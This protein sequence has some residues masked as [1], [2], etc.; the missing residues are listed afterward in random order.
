M[1]YTLRHIR[2]NLDPAPRVTLQPADWLA[3]GSSRSQLFLWEAFVSGAAHAREANAA[4]LQDHLVDAATA[5]LA[6]AQWE[7][8]IPRGPSDVT[9]QN[10]ISTVGAAVLWSGLASDPDLLHQQTLVLRPT[11]LLGAGIVAYEP[12]PIQQR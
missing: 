11:Q 9:A 3:S 2:S 1:S 7:A 10:P 6:F 12:P 4:G 8:T 5:V